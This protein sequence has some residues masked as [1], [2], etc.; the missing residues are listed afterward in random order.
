MAG[1]VAKVQAN[2]ITLIP[3]LMMFGVLGCCCLAVGLGATF[4]MKSSRSSRQLTRQQAALVQDVQPA[5]EEALLDAE[6]GVTN[7]GGLL[8]ATEDAE[9][10]LE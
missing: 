1:K 3:A 2:G 8:R 4:R 7:I 10:G 6:A 5:N 9:A